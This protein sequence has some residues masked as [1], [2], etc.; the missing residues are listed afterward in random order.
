M[1]LYEFI[2]FLARFCGFFLRIVKIRNAQAIRDIGETNRVI[3]GF[4]DDLPT[5]E[6]EWLVQVVGEFHA[7]VYTTE[8]I[9]CQRFLQAAVEL[10]WKHSICVVGRISPYGPVNELVI[11]PLRNIGERKNGQYYHFAI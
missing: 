5:F 4:D 11:G 6:V 3:D 7:A 1:L 9:V 10:L 2:Q 8:W